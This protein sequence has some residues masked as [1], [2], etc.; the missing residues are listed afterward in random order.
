[1]ENKPELKMNWTNLFLLCAFNFCLSLATK[2][3][4]WNSNSTLILVIINSLFW[5][6]PI[7]S[8]KLPEK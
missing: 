3:Y 2:H 6:F 4:G 5:P 7:L 8:V 1:M